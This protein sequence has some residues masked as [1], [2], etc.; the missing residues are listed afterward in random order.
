[1]L[2]MKRMLLLIPF[3]PLV[4]DSITYVPIKEVFCM[5]SFLIVRFYAAQT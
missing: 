2:I 3:T 5:L 4:C 1:M